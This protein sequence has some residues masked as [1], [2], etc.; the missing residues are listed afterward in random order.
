MSELHMCTNHKGYDA[1][2]WVILVDIVQH[3]DLDMEIGDDAI[4]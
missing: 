2:L 3:P 1:I 4:L